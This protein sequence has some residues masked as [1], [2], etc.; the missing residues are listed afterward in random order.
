MLTHAALLRPH[1]AQEP[2]TTDSKLLPSPAAVQAEAGSS[3]ALALRLTSNLNSDFNLESD[4]S[5]TQTHSSPF[6][7]CQLEALTRPL[8]VSTEPVTV[9]QAS[10]SA[11]SVPGLVT[12]HHAMHFGGSSESDSDSSS[13]WSRSDLRPEPP[14]QG[15]NDTGS[16]LGE[17]E[18][19]SE[20]DRDGRASLTVPLAFSSSGRCPWQD[21]HPSDLQVQEETVSGCE[22]AVECPSYGGT[23][24]TTIPATPLPAQLEAASRPE[25]FSSMAGM[26]LRPVQRGRS[27]V[28]WDEPS[29]MSRRGLNRLQV[30]LCAIT[31]VLQQE[32]DNARGA[33]PGLPLPL[34]VV[35]VDSEAL[36]PSF[37]LP[38]AEPGHC[39]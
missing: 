1:A 5:L 19:E 27:I 8:S 18:S 11:T 9:M 30:G 33:H 35:S 22:S 29:L 12:L 32:G 15:A 2:W 3:V 28:E 17:S 16:D 20:S 6:T 13:S 21:R 10:L 14:L 38:Q 25:S 36:H 4:W 24:S 34:T 39:A 7:M 31:P 23:S 26:R 37:K